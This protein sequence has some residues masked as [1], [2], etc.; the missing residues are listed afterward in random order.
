MN[1]LIFAL[2]LVLLYVVPVSSSDAP[3]A[4]HINEYVYDKSFK[5]LKDKSITVHSLKGLNDLVKKEYDHLAPVHGFVIYKTLSS[6]R[7]L[8]NYGK[9]GVNYQYFYYPRPTH[10]IEDPNSIPESPDIDEFTKW[11]PAKDTLEP[12]V[13]YSREHH[14]YP[15]DWCSTLLQYF[16]PSLGQGF[17]TKFANA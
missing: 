8:G 14:D 10:V 4:P 6:M 17:C 13:P 12:Y 1:K 11:V 2:L 3:D 5:S 9:K 15:Q 7:L 16:F